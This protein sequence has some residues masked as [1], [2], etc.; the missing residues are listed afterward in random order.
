MNIDRIDSALF[1]AIFV[2][3]IVFISEFFFPDTNSFISIIIGA[4]SALIGGLIANKIFPEESG[5]KT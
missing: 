5:K 4:L 1:T 3:I 2:G